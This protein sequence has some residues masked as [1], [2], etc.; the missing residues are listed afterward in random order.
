MMMMMML[1]I[2][3]K[4]KGIRTLSTARRQKNAHFKIVNLMRSPIT[5]RH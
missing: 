3:K 5:K 1:V 4:K 2:K